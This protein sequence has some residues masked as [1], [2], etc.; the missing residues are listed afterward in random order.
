MDKGDDRTVRK[1][2]SEAIELDDKEEV[3]VLESCATSTPGLATTAVLPLLSQSSTG[4]NLALPQ[5]ALWCLL[6][7]Q[8]VF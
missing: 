7:R 4:T 8:A 2:L 3:G 1:L 5:L 6:S